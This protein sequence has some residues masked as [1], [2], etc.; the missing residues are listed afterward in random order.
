MK[1][2]PVIASVA[3][4]LGDP[5][6]A[7][8]LTA[9]IDGRALTV[10]EL[11][12]AAGVTIQTASGHLAKL[13]DAHLL[14]GEKQGRHRYFRLSGPDV[15]QVLEALMG[16]AQRTGAVRVRVG[17]TDEALRSARICYDHLAGE[18][19]VAMLDSLRRRRLIAGD[20]DLALTP[21]GRD[22]FADFGIDLPSLE[23]GRRPLCRACLDWSERR[24]HLGGALGAAILAQVMDRDWARRDGRTLLFSHD[25]LKQFV[26]HI[27]PPD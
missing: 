23:R 3:A 4:L 26:E 12:R 9:L 5:A 21:S 27:A 17:P 11:A 13:A 7:N 25:G 19:G 16:L 6:R 10:S 20:E 8:I 24:S 1:E 14:V 2:G 18:R 22:F 15:A